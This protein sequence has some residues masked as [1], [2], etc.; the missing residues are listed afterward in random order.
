MSASDQTKPK[1]LAKQTTERVFAALNRADEI[2]DLEEPEHETKPAPLSTEPRQH[3]VPFI[4][5]RGQFVGGF[6]ALSEIDR[7]GQLEVAMMSPAE[8]TTGP[9]HLKNVGIV[10]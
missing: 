8:E 1:T 10:P 4:Y 5:L 7:L 6:N 3:T 9:A 2:G